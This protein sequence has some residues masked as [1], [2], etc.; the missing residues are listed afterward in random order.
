[1]KKY[2]PI[3]KDGLI[4][5]AFS[6]VFAVICIYAVN[7]LKGSG[8][9]TDPI[10]AA[11]IQDDIEQMKK[12][13]TQTSERVNIVDEQGRT[14]LMW[15]AYVN[16][17]SAE[18]VEKNEAKRI[19]ATRLLIEKGADVAKR[20]KD[21]WTALTW[22][23]WSGFPKVSEELIN[24]NI[25]INAKDK[26]GNTALMVAAQRGNTA[27]VSLLLSKQADKTSKNTEGMGALELAQ[28]SLKEF[29]DKAT[30]YQKIVAELSK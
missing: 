11:I 17:K 19:E 12:D 24:K 29:P 1:M 16:F 5:M 8:V 27:I 18:K 4:L 23:A 2:M 22:A 10:I 28:K 9:K 21:G 7:L 3:I 26:K 6:S 14:P 20:D 15:A 13:I 30:E 25:D